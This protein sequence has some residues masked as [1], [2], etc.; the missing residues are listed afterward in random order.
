[1]LSNS[2][3][4]APASVQVFIFAQFSM[5]AAQAV[6]T[7]DVKPVLLAQLRQD[8]PTGI[9]KENSALNP[10][11]Q[12]PQMHLNSSVT[13]TCEC[14]DHRTAP[15][16]TSNDS[17][18]KCLGKCLGTPGPQTQCHGH[19]IGTVYR[20]LPGCLPETIETRSLVLQL[21]RLTHCSEAM[22]PHKCGCQVR[23]LK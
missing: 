14:C 16:I 7:Q 6:K 22:Q 20:R 4:T 13:S 23:Q 9:N 2:Q 11:T 5:G 3:I 12:K 8:R 21:S 10:C 15:W 19:V 17:K 18:K 1:M